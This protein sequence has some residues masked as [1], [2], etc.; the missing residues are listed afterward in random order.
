[1][2]N[3]RGD[4]LETYNSMT[5]INQESHQVLPQSS[6]FCKSKEPPDIA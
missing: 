4:I 1:M 6:E 5:S 3:G 2:S